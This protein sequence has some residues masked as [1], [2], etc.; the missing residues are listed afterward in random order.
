MSHRQSLGEHLLIYDADCAFCTYWVGYLQRSLPV[1][2]TP[3][4]SKDLD[5]DTWGLSRDD[6]A[7]FAWYLTPTHQ[8]AGHLAASALLRVQPKVWLRFLGHL[9]AT[10]PFS[11]IAAGVYR[12]VATYRGK[13]PYGK[14]PPHPSGTP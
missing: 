8:Y 2:P 9:I 14:T 11:L 7:R 12:L 6:V 10:P 13:L 1:F 5:I 4:A 3:V